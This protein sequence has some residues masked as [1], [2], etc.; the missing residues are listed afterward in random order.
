MWYVKAGTCLPHLLH[1]VESREGYV[2]IEVSSIE[3]DTQ[4]NLNII[5]LMVV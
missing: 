1:V 2:I 5:S 4:I 3:V